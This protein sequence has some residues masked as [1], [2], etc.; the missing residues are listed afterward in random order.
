MSS[1]SGMI[2]ARLRQQEKLANED[3]TLQFAPSVFFQSN[4]NKIK[5]SLCLENSCQQGFTFYPLK[6]SG[7]QEYI[8]SVVTCLEKKFLNSQITITVEVDDHNIVLNSDIPP[9]VQDINEPQRF[10]I[11]TDQPDIRNGMIITGHS[12][13][14]LAAQTGGTDFCK[15]TYYNNKYFYIN[16]QPVTKIPDGTILSIQPMTNCIGYN[17]TEI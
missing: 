15:I 10:R 8:N 2:R 13:L 17:L 4:I 3:S 5:K 9:T 16:P 6:T 1:H 7:N 14:S 11:T 12:A